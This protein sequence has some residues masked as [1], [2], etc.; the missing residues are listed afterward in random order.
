MD[1]V[2]PCWLM[3]FDGVE[4]DGAGLTWGPSTWSPAKL[5]AAQRLQSL[6]LGWK[7]N[8]SL[9]QSLPSNLQSLTFGD[10]FNQSLDR[11]TLPS[12]LQILTFGGDFNQSLE[13]VALPSHLQSLTVSSQ[14]I[15]TL[16]RGTL[17]SNLQSLTISLIKQ[18]LHRVALPNNLLRLTLDMMLNQSLD[19]VTLP[20]NLQSL[21][22]GRGFNQSLDRVTLPSNLQSLTL[23]REFNQSV[24]R[25]TLPMPSNLQ[26]LTFGDS[27]NQSLDRV[28]L[29]SNLQ[30][31]TFGDLFNQSLDRVTLPSNLQILT[32]GGDFNQSLNR[33]TLPSNLQILTFGYMFNQSLE[34]MTLPNSLQSLTFGTQFNQSLEQV[35]LPSSLQSLTFSVDFNQSLDR[36]TLPSN[37]QSL[38]LGREFNQSLY[39]VA[40]PNSLHTLTLGRKFSDCLEGV[41]LPVGDLVGVVV[42]FQGELQQTHRR[43]RCTRRVACV[44]TGGCVWRGELRRMS[45]QGDSFWRLGQ[46]G[47]AASQRLSQ[48]GQ[49]VGQAINDTAMRPCVSCGQ[50]YV[51]AGMMICTECHQL[52]C[53][54][55]WEVASFHGPAAPS[56]Q[57]ILCRGCIPLVRKRY[58]DENVQLRLKRTEAF[59]TSQ[60]EPF[61]YDPESKLEQTLRLSGHVMQGLKKFSSFI[62]FSQAAQ[63]IEAGYYLV[64]YGPLILAGNDIMES[65]QLILGLAKKLELPAYHRLASPDFFGGLYYSMGEHWGQRGRV[66]EMETAQHTVDGEVPAVDRGQLLMLRH[67]TR[68]LLVSKES[69]P[70]DAQRLL[71]QAMPG[72]ELVL[73][74]MSSVPAIPSFFLVCSREAKVAYL[75]MPGTRKLSDLVTDFNAT[76]EPFGDGFGHRGMV[77]AARWMHEQ[78]GPA[79]IRL[80]T[81]GYRITLLGHSL[82]AGVGALLTL[83]L[84]PHISNLCCYGFGTPACVD[85][86]LMPQLL[87]CMVS[88]VNRD[89]L[90]P[91]L[92]V[93]S[94]QGL[95]ESVLCPGQVAKTQAWM[96]EDWQAVK[97]FERIIEL[98]RRG[99]KEAE[100]D[101]SAS[102]NN[103]VS[104]DESMKLMMLMEVSPAF[105]V[106]AGG[107]LLEL[108][109]QKGAEN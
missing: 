27:F 70:T 75:V 84:R 82:G 46:L 107:D 22:L 87:N 50:P 68:L 97:D 19:R 11:V 72:A 90:V 65:F 44:A 60:L 20:S 28:T 103:D 79:L 17:L 2:D 45:S 43:M 32:F 85:E 26:S 67:L 5:K 96:K 54:N 53:R 98:R 59:L 102:P 42:T 104:E 71:R 63:A 86:N 100:G 30:I 37:L 4:W 94:V 47:G 91:R 76:E 16:Q 83:I 88:V 36:V 78:V 105:R 41:T 73:A 29:P 24:D 14:S 34:Q 77:E 101:A 25:V 109:P 92:S 39:R 61:S 99:Q 31:L 9:E 48:L 49:Q 7:Y 58:S 69:T 8:Q 21:T 74:E 15:R 1:E 35:T 12:N 33:V 13:G 6:T 18:S 106:I 80:Y 57:K 52:A 23:G 3:G 56:S 81:S 93:N 62:P 38:V 10:S 40:I 89:D 55:C 51:R 66:P 95:L 64:R 108:K